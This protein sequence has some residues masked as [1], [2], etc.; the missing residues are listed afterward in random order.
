MIPTE[1]PEVTS[2]GIRHVFKA[3]AWGHH[4]WLQQSLPLSKARPL[5][6]LLPL[7]GATNHSWLCPVLVTLP[8]P[9]DPTVDWELI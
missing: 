7:P 1:A 6:H 8:P 5:G 3:A 9:P 2:T 4:G